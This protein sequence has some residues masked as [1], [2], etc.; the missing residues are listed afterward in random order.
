MGERFVLPS[1]VLFP[2]GAA[3]LGAQGLIEIQRVADILLDIAADLPGDIDWVLRIDGHTDKQPIGANSAFGS[4][5]R[6][7]TER[8][9]AVSD[10]LIQRGFPA[11]RLAVTGF[12]EFQPLVDEDSAEAYRQNRRIELRLTQR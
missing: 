5:W 6:L 11:E 4:N 2:S 1:E 10:F 9:L 12:G 3:T 8:A 7:S